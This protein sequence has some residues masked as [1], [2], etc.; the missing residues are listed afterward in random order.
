MASTSR[1]VGGGAAPP[2]RLLLG[3]I[4]CH[5]TF[6]D[7]AETPRAIL[8][9]AGAA[10]LD[11]LAI[12]DHLPAPPGAAA[13]PPSSTPM[14]EFPPADSGVVRVPALEYSPSSNHFLVLG[15]DPWEAPDPADLA[16]WPKA[17]SYVGM[18]SERPGLLGFLA[19]PDDEGNPFLGLESYR[20]TDWDVAGYTGLEVW[21]L[22]TDLA[23][24]VRGY[25]DILRVALAGLYRAVPPP[26]PDTLARWD[27]L[28]QRGRVV[29]IAGTDAHAYPARWHGLH[30][31]VVPYE[32]AFRS[33]QTA[34]W[35]DRETAEG[36]P[37][38]RIGGI[39]EALG[40]GRAFMVNRVWGHPVGFV[41]QARPTKTTE[42][43]FISG[44][45]I[46]AGRPVRFEVSTPVSTW[47]RLIRN[48]L[49]V[50]NTYGRELI[51][52]P[53]DSDPAPAGAVW[54]AWRT[55]VWVASSHWN[56]AGSGFFLWIL[57]NHI[58]RGIG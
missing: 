29:G 13:R 14:A 1:G 38:A 47:I 36:S 45:V 3:S 33:L 30:L 53:L 44:E 9:K 27:R 8:A 32:R 26:H 4:H 15:I 35:V 28:A 56:Q 20:W 49:P 24:T 17:S 43:P 6:S 55:E 5:S 34:V 50:A 37:P 7:G 10:G 22:S 12:S 58:Y 52:E 31:T 23:R 25:R 16:G 2:F 18:V 46:P 21:N 19:H 48:G 39:L 54:E 57:S 42:R 11:F 40:R 41:F 51:F